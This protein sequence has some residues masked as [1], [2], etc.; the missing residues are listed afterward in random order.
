MIEWDKLDEEGKDRVASKVLKWLKNV[1]AEVAKNP[2]LI[3]WLGE[4]LRKNEKLIYEC[5][6]W[7]SKPEFRNY[8]GVVYGIIIRT[9]T[10]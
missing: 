2:E 6:K 3:E 10:A 5:I 7:A 1:T 4:E 9:L 8:I